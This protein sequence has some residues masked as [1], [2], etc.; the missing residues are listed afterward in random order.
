M[1]AINIINN[2]TQRLTTRL[3]TFFLLVAFVIGGVFYSMFIY[4]I[5][6]TEDEVGAKRIA[7]D[8]QVA[9]MRYQSGETGKLNIDGLTDAYNDVSLVPQGYLNYAEGKDSFVGEVTNERGASRMLYIGKYEKNNTTKPL[10]LLS[11]IDEIELSPSEF[12]FVIM[13]AL[14]VV[15]GLL[16]LFTVIL[17]F[18][19]NNLI[20][21]F[22]SL[23]I[24]FKQD[25]KENAKPFTVSKH[26]ALEFTQLTEQL[27]QYKAN[28]LSLVKREQA[29]SRYTSHELRTPLTVVKGATGLL[30]RQKNTAFQLKQLKLISQAT[31]QMISM[32]DALL[33]LVRYENNREAAPMRRVSKHELQR[34]IDDHLQLIHGESLHI[35]LE[36]T[37]EPNIQASNAVLNMVVGNLLRNAISASQQGDILVTMDRVSI[38]VIDQGKGLTDE[39]FSQGH[40]LGLILVQ[41][42]CLRFHW[43]FT[44]D[45]DD[46]KGTTARVRF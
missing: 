3:A 1:L 20:A 10:I 40:G 22:N 8:A 6:W 21:P 7:L 17:I 14:T 46:V 41:D 27:N 24:Q 31:E 35:H 26:S 32:V 9:V 44:I 45:S 39:P 16:A 15:L 42:L 19:S 5:Q 12:D 11:N 4:A 43:Q 2:S 33:S 13:I 18:L 28:L 30:L 37:D 25:T 34:I 23:A 38:S 36:V 29:F